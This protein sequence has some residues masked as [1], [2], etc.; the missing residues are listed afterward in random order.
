M[1]GRPIESLAAPPIF[2]VGMAR[3]GT[4]WVY[5]ILTS[6]PEVGGVL[7]SWLFTN[8]GVKPLFSASHWAAE[9]QPSTG[10]GRVMTR[11]E[12]VSDVR[13]LVSRW[14]TR[15][16]EPSQRFLVEKSPNHVNSVALISELVPD[17]RFI[18]V[19]RDGRD[20]AVSVQAA[21]KSWAPLWKK[22]FGGSLEVCAKTWRSAVLNA[23]RARDELGVPFLEVRYEELKAHPTGAIAEMFDF[24]SVPYDDTLIERIRRATTFDPRSGGATRFRRTGRIGEWRQRFSQE[25][26]ATF[27][28]V[29]G[30]VLVATGYE[31]NR[32]WW[33]EHERE[34]GPRMA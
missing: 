17:A 10:L 4:T 7:E 32:A 9:G 3:S 14:L 6:H 26:A 29:A 16:L 18:H 34:S 13:D 23:H 21:S 25:D 8:E 24:C 22:T 12:L 15:A 33:T 28:A 20:V 19:L 27:D 31:R 5:S 1:T 2:V 11:Q 30:D